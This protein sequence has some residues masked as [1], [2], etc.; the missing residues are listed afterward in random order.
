[1]SVPLPELTL[2]PALTLSF[3]FCG[4]P[5]SMIPACRRSQESPAVS[6]NA[7]ARFENVKGA[8]PPFENAG[9]GLG[10]ISQRTVSWRGVASESALHFQVHVAGVAYCVPLTW[11]AA[12][13]FTDFGGA[14]TSG[15]PFAAFS[16]DAPVPAHVAST[17]FPASYVSVHV[18]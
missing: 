7:L 13:N 5:A 3:A 8:L 9:G 16:V 14:T 17:P 12:G 11:L 6:V 4:S 1:M 18:P 15:D 10:S 2:P